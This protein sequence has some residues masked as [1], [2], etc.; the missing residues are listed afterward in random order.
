[1]LQ[2][3]SHQKNCGRLSRVVEKLPVQFLH[4]SV[5]YMWD[6]FHFKCFHIEYRLLYLYIYSDS[7]C[8]VL[9][10]SQLLADAQIWRDLQKCFWSFYQ[11]GNLARKA[12]SISQSLSISHRSRCLSTVWIQPVTQ[13]KHLGDIHDFSYY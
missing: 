12:H 6:L 10:R 5:Q 1:M 11:W 7:Y 9:L 2:K 8:L 3:N 13:L 4:K